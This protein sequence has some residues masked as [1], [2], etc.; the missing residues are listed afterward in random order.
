[1]ALVVEII[2]PLIAVLELQILDGVL[3]VL[4]VGL[5]GNAHP[6]IAL[7]PD[8]LVGDGGFIEFAWNLRQAGPRRWGE[9]T[10]SLAD[11]YSRGIEWDF[12][13]R[14]TWND[15]FLPSVLGQNLLQHPIWFAREVV[16]QLIEH[17]LVGLHGLLHPIHPC[18]PPRRPSPALISI[19]R[20]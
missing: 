2:R 20:A 9:A 1:L 4:A 19:G 12:S 5:D 8:L 6:L 7:H 17:L 18:S 10:V 15:R 3:G 11:Q 13:I 14:F 16:S